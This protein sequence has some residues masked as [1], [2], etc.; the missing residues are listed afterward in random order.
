MPVHDYKDIGLFDGKSG[1]LGAIGK[2]GRALYQIKDLDERFR[3]FAEDRAYNVG[4]DYT[5]LPSSDLGHYV[6]RIEKPRVPNREWGV[7]VGEVVHNLRSALDQAVYAASVSPSRDNEFPVCRDPDDWDRRSSKL[8]KGVPPS[9]VKIIR[10]A[11]PFRQRDVERHEFLLL[12]GMWNHDKHRLLHTTALVVGEPRPQ[13]VPLADVGEIVQVEWLSEPLEERREV[14][15]V[16]IRPSGA[17]PKMTLEGR[18]PVGVAFAE[19]VEGA[20]ALKG[21]H[22]LAVLENAFRV[23]RSVVGSLEVACLKV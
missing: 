11:Q 3:A 12:H 2:I 15:R 1:F 6:F 19:G 16:T 10:S 17:N 13:V 20:P 5:A 14:A 7:L 8:L 4:S 23:V 18:L 21:L 22:V 9:A